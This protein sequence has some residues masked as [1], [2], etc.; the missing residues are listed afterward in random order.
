MPHDR[1]LLGIMLMLGFCIVAPFADALLK[2]LGDRLS[3]GQAVAFRFGVQAALLWPLTLVTGRAWRMSPRLIGFVMLRTALHITGIGLVFLALRHMPIADAVAIAYVM[4]FILLLLGW[5]LLNEEIGPRRL[6]ACVVGFIGA[7]MVIQPAFADVGLAALLPLGVALVFA[8]FML[9]T[10]H[11]ANDTDPVGMQA[12]SASMAIVVL[13][14]ML[15][16]APGEPGGP[17]EWRALSMQV[18]WL[19]ALMGTLG[20]FTHLLMTWA[21]R[22]APASSLA[23]MQYIE[24]PMAAAV[25]WMFFDDLPGPLA[26]LGIVVTVAAGLYVVMLERAK[27]APPAPAPV[28]APTK[29]PAAE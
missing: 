15:A 26:S 9:V 24:I 1:P 18:V 25:G 29:P 3:V 7:M 11:I 2:L 22:F 21:L 13:G 16:L 5:L 8:L 17:L 23:P 12:V 28:P 19:I 4:P 10:R 6:G 14:P 20:T 27:S